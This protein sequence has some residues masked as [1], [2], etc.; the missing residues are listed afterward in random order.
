LT[1]VVMAM[2]V[3]LI[4][5]MFSSDL[6]DAGQAK[7]LSL[8]ILSGLC[9]LVALFSTIVLERIHGSR[10]KREEHCNPSQDRHCGEQSNEKKEDIRTAAVIEKPEEEKMPV[11]ELKILETLAGVVG[12]RMT[13]ADILRH[14]MIPQKDFDETI[15]LM[16]AKG[17]VVQELSGGGKPILVLT[18]RGRQQVLSEFPLRA[19]HY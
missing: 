10:I 19:G 5:N 9:I 6:L 16:K 7:P 17:L 4:L 18:T 13:L 1:G 3:P 14:T 11:N 2:T 15:S 8:F 12:T